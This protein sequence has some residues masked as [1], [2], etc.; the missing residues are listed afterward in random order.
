MPSV[1]DTVTALVLLPLDWAA[2]R[3][4]PVTVAAVTVAAVTV[5][6]VAG[7]DPRVGVVAVAAPD[8]AGSASA[9]GFAHVVSR[10]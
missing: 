6:V 8:A 4:R 5:A 10:L 2:A 1:G 9:V 7:T 3:R